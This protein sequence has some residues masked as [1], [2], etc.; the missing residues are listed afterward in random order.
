MANQLVV[1]NVYDMVSAAGGLLSDRG[2]PP[3]APG[4]EGRG[5]VD[6][7]GLAPGLHTESLV[8]AAGSAALRGPKSS[9]GVPP[10]PSA[11]STVPRGGR[12]L[13]RDK[14]CLARRRWVLFLIDGN[15]RTAL[16]WAKLGRNEG[17]AS[18]GFAVL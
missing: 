13:C 2:D 9:R 15:S 17:I 4:R 10:G 12:W 5:P 18:A 7:R 1:L 6:A 3:G 8:C 11:S 14:S 16:V